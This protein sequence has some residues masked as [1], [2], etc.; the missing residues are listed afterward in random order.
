MFIKFLLPRRS[1]VLTIELSFKFLGIKKIF[2]IIS[3]L[4]LDN[5][6]R[7]Q[8]IPWYIFEDFLFSLNR[9]PEIFVCFLFLKWR[10]K[11]PITYIFQ[12]G[13]FS[14]FLVRFLELRL[15]LKLSCFKLRIP[16]RDSLVSLDCRF[17]Y[18]FFLQSNLR[19][20]E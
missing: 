6:G 18:I 12:G 8:E 17:L 11:Y 19:S 4:K 9:Q 16:I 14:L 7:F 2:L 20:R 15:S 10:N 13:T 5:F 3:G 1:I